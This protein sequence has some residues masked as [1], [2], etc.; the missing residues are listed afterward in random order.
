MIIYVKSFPG[1]QYHSEGPDDTV[2]ARSESGWIDSELFVIRLKKLFLKYAVSHTQL[3]SSQ[4]ST[5]LISILMSLT[6]AVV[7][8]SSFLFTST[9]YPCVAASGCSCF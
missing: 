8:M 2:Y 3:S 7:M 5:S 4:I 6:F 1:G 9:H